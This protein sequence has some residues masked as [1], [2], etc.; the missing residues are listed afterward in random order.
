VIPFQTQT[1]KTPRVVVSPEPARSRWKPA[2]DDAGA[3]YDVFGANA[4][5][6]HRVAVFNSF[7]YDKWFRVRSYDTHNI[8]Q[9]G[10]GILVANHSGNLPLDAVMI[11]TDVLRRTEPARLVR[12]IAH[13]VF[14]AVPLFSTLAARTGV[15]GGT[16]ANVRRLLTRG[17]LLLIFPEGVPGILKGFRQRYKL[18]DFTVGHVEFALRHRVPIYPVAVIGAEEQLPAALSVRFGRSRIRSVSVPLFPIPLPVRYHI[19]YGAP[20]HL[21]QDH[22]PESADLP[23]VLEACARQTQDAVQA[24]V[25]KGRNERKGVFA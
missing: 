13:H 12:P 1:Q 15:V 16:R 25:N 3:G 10:G 14:S 5:W 19:H 23:S 6:A 24:L 2:I 20:L 22:P 8:P 17:E 11:W 21:Y 9:H 7:L 18:R 4:T